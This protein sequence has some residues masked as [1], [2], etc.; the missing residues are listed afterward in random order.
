MK[1]QEKNPAK[2]TNERK[3]LSDRVQNINNK[4]AN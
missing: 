2:I 4:N 3:N 1:E